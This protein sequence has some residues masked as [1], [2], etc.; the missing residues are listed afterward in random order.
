MSFR[1]FLFLCL[2]LQ[3]IIFADDFKL[4][5]YGCVTD[6]KQEVKR[7]VLL[8]NITEENLYVTYPSTFYFYGKK[9]IE[10]IEGRARRSLRI[11][12]L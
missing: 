9:P 8:Q 12:D 7:V 1:L 2:F 5:D 4:Y 3:T 11:L 6:E 10:P